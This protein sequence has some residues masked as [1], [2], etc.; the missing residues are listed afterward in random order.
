[1]LAEDRE[2]KAADIV[3][4]QETRDLWRVVPVRQSDREVQAHESVPVHA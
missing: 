2:R 4:V 3:D 1:M